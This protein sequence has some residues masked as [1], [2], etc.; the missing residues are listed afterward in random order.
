MSGLLSYGTYA[1][2]KPWVTVYVTA[3]IDGRIASRTGDSK[4]SCPYDLRRLHAARASSDAVMVGANTIIRDDPLLTVRLA[5]GPNP[6]RVVVDGRLRSPLNARIFSQDPFKTI[7]ISSEAAPREKLE[8]LRRR[9]VNVRLLGGADGRVDMALALHDLW[10]LG[11]RR[12]LV[13]GGG[14]LIWSLV[15]ENLVDE[16]RVTL[17]PLIIGGS[18]SVPMVGG[19]G[20]DTVLHALRLHLVSHTLCECGEEI[21]LIYRRIP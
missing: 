4:L 17:T 5:P 15:E 8:E 16:F 13:E 1:L 9:G 2:R 19:R 21:H 7:L 6:L 12:L 11:V 3:S 14:K 20:F 18:E 10:G